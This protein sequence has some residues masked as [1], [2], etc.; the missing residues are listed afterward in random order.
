MKLI[1][2]G[3]S[4]LLGLILLLQ[5]Q[6]WRQ[7][8]PTSP[9][10]AVPAELL[11]GPSDPPPSAELGILQPEDDYV[12][13][14]ER[15]LFL[16]DRRPAPEAS[17]AEQTPNLDEEIAELERLDVTATLILSPTEASVWLR[18]LGQKDL[19]R[20]RPGDQY[21]GWTV[22]QINRDHILMERQGVTEKLELLDFSKPALP[23]P[24]RPARAAPP[25]RG[26]QA[27]DPSQRGSKRP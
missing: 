5:W 27:P 16:P 13:V 26:R 25:A 23:P 1:L 22:A 15:P 19:V 8:L 4:M 6:D 3:I 10:A 12:A 21:Q 7:Q 24:R 18:D 2:L 14:M 11:E 17:D 9:E 20:L